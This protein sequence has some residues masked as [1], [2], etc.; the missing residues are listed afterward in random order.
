MLLT[1]LN[2]RA[3][4]FINIIDCCVYINSSIRLIMALSWLYGIF[5]YDFDNTCILGRVTTQENSNFIYQHSSFQLQQ[6][7]INDKS[8]KHWKCLKV[9]CDFP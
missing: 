9:L 2:N 6:L 7:P 5:I 1:L 4:D 3:V 8:L